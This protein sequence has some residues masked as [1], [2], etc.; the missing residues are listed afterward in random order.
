MRMEGGR[1]ECRTDAH[2]R[3]GLKDGNNG[4]IGNVGN[5]LKVGNQNY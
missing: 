5:V 1:E 2:S 4:N 3:P